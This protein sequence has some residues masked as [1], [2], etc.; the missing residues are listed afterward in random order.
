MVKVRE[1]IQMVIALILT[2]A[3][4]GLSGCA[5]KAAG[6][7]GAQPAT[8]RAASASSNPGSSAPASAAVEI[9]IDNFSFNP[10]TLTISPGTKVTWI[11][12]DDVPHT[13]T[14]SA[15]V[16]ASPALDTGGHF[17]FTFEHPGEY[18]YFCAVHPHMTGKVI[19][20]AN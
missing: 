2:V 19:V 15:K 11:N 12:H 10:A 14:S 7:S 13:A 17:S 3:T 20:K 4:I 6:Q 8:A 16:F 18:A 5:R 9:G 1:T